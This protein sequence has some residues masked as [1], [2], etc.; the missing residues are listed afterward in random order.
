VQLG[1][2]APLEDA[3]LIKQAG[4]DYIEYPL[5]AQGLEDRTTFAAA[6]QTIAESPLPAAAC[7]YFMPQDMRVVG[8]DVDVP[9]VKSYLAY[10][11]ELMGSA[12]TRSCV[13]GAAWARN[14]PD[15]W[16]RD[17]AEVQFLEA[18][19]WC[20]DALQGTGVTLAIEP[21]Y[22]KES[23]FINSVA[24]GAHF[25]RLVNRAEIRVLADFFHM[26]EEDEPFETLIEHR[27]WLAHV[28]LA[29]TGRKN[30]GT[31][32]YPYDRFFAALQEAG[33]DRLMSCECSVDDRQTG[34]R[35]S[36]NFLRQRWSEQAASRP[37]LRRETTR[38]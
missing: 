4:F 20:A 22:R 31:G 17:R 14:I 29:D 1:W 6:M 12:R 8:P 38:P 13:F 37:G 27:E 3:D 19:N 21:L 35:H 36:V 7:N 24:E 23:N 30:P 15:G 2:C 33:Y 16:E 5:A 34:L 18:L 25:A 11:A 32:S 9:R 28:H 26:D 10:A